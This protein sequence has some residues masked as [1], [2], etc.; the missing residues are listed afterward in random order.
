MNRGER[1][2]G[3]MP[4]FPA[5]AA[6]VRKPDIFDGFFLFLAAILVLCSIFMH[7]N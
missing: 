4:E 5:R 6:R 3:F 2:R 7:E 1:A